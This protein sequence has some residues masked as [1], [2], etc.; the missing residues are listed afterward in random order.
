LH[1]KSSLFFYPEGGGDMFLRNVYLFYRATRPYI[2]ENRTLVFIQ[3][4]SR[5]TTFFV[6]ESGEYFE[7]RGVGGLGVE[8]ARVG[9]KEGTYLYV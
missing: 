9:E 2:L 1:T 3:F 7:A 5:A 4:V 6:R 8:W